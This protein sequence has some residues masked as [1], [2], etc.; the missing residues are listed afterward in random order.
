M[1]RSRC[2]H[3][4]SWRSTMRRTA[5]RHAAAP[6]ATI[7]KACR[8]CGG[9]EPR[10]QWPFQTTVH[11]PSSR[12][13]SRVTSRLYTA[14]MRS[15]LAPP[16]REPQAATPSPVE[17]PALAAPAWFSADSEDIVLD[18]C[19]GYCNH[20]ADCLDVVE[21]SVFLV[22]THPIW[23]SGFV[24]RLAARTKRSTPS[25]EAP[26]AF[27]VLTTERKAA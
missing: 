8:R 13:A 12:S 2:S 22:I 21:P 4:C 7:K 26:L 27:A 3:A 23:A 18:L 20:L 11:D 1:N 9:K 25:T 19:L 15:A 24:V 14:R 5:D 17:K 16:N 10:W 6:G